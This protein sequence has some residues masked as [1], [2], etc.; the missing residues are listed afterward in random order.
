MGA[1]VSLKADRRDA[2]FLGRV[3]ALPTSV[4]WWRM[5]EVSILEEEN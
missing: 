3:A 2:F 1:G 5:G 4:W